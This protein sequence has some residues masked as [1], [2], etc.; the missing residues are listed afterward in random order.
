[1]TAHA[2]PSIVAKKAVEGQTVMS[3]SSDNRKR[4]LSTIALLASA[5]AGTAAFVSNLETIKTFFRPKPP[6]IASISIRE[7]IVDGG[8][9]E[10][11]DPQIGSDEREFEWCVL[12]DAIV[13]KSRGVVRNCYAQLRYDGDAEI[14]G[15]DTCPLDEATTQIF[16][17]REE[18]NSEKIR[19]VFPSSFVWLPEGEEFEFTYQIFCD[20][21]IS[22]SIKFPYRLIRPQYG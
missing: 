3:N 21:V 15:K 13:E 9:I 14:E 18:S 7:L 12:T 2:N 8:D 16:G 17:M 6:E 5:V 19:V 11:F 20:G 22:N 4:A 1:M 10:T